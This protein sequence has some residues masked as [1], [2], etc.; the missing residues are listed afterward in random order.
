MAAQSTALTSA[1]QVGPPARV[2][3][4]PSPQGLLFLLD[5]VRVA[6]AA[7]PQQLPGGLRS[8]SEGFTPKAS[9]KGTSREAST[10]G[11]RSARRQLERQR[12]ADAVSPAHVAS[13]PRAGHTPRGALCA[14]VA[15]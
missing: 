13:T 12:S 9:P 11:Q 2:R 3:A 8:V 15:R 10:A 14:F 4:I 1:Q 7:R 5:R 6:L